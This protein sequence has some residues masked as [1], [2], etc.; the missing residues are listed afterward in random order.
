MITPINPLL[1]LGNRVRVSYNFVGYSDA[2]FFSPSGMFLALTHAG[3]GDQVPIPHL[4][5][6]EAA[7]AL[8]NFEHRLPVLS[9]AAALENGY[10][11]QLSPEQNEA[12][13]Y[14]LPLDEK[15]RVADP[16]LPLDID[17]VRRLNGLRNKVVHEGYDPTADQAREAAQI[18]ETITTYLVPLEG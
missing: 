13:R 10:R 15:V 14:L 1:L 11:T 8:S 17:E 12:T 7:T 4:L 6:V 2:L 16:Q 3:H 9:A 18:A 5:L